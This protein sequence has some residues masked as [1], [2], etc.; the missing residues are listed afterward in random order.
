MADALDLLF[1]HQLGHPLLQRLLVDLI[2]Q[3]VDDDRLTLAAVDVLE[4]ALGAHHD[5]SPSGSVAVL[6]AVDAVD[7]A[8]GWK[9]G[10]RDDLHQL[11]D[12]RVRVA[13]QVQ[14]G[15][16]HF[17]EVVRRYVGRHSNRDAA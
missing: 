17:V 1:V 8:G 6:Y 9:V 5:A 13:Q 12:R 16:D 14:A 15:V 4:V 10:R 2:R 3:L 11:V 7:D